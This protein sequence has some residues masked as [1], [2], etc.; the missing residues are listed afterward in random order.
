MTHSLPCAFA[1]GRFTAIAAA[2]LCTGLVGQTAQAATTNLYVSPTGLDTYDCSSLANACSLRHA[3]DRVR[4]LNANM[5]GDII[6]NLAAGSYPLTSTFQLNQLDSG[7]NG[8][9]VIYQGPTNVA[10]PAVL[11]GGKAITGWTVHDSGKNIWKATLPSGVDF[12]Q[13][14]VNGN[15]A[16][17]ARWPNVTNVETGE[18]Y[19]RAVSTVSNVNGTDTLKFVVR[20]ADFKVPSNLVGT[21]VVW[22]NHW[23]HLRARIASFT[24]NSP[25]TQQTTLNFQSPEKANPVFVHF[26]QSNSP[27]YYENALSMLDAPGEWFLDTMRS[28]RV[29]YYIPRA[30]ESMSQAQVAA[31]QVQTLLELA[32]T[33]TSNIHHVQIRNLSFKHSNWHTPSQ[34]GYGVYQSAT[35]LE[36]NGALV[37]AAVSVKNADTVA[38]ENNVLTATGAHGLLLS[39]NVSNYRVVHNQLSDLSAGGIYDEADLSTN[40]LM[41]GNLI[42]KVGRAYTDA[43]GVLAMVPKQ[44]TISYNEIRQTPYTGISLGWRWNNVDYGYDNNQVLNNRIHSVMQVQDDG[45]GIYTLGRM[46]NTVFQGNYVYDIAVAS[47]F[48]GFPSVGIYL[49]QGSTGRT[50]TGN[51]VSNAY[52]YFKINNNSQDTA[53]NSFTGNYYNGA[54]F[55]VTAFGTNTVSGNV[56]VAP[57]SAWPTEAVNIMNNAGI[58]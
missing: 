46:N 49:D 51:V 56:Y 6:V 36:G 24:V 27:F 41:S 43:A 3:R 16:I 53:N 8:Y 25:A 38:L 19:L 9:A 28:P 54:D 40:G 26:P 30:G 39:G 14:Y 12:R 1:R 31:P 50:V 11:S 52:Q 13:L 42:E 55:G 44:L 48:G 7:S 33:S 35:I 34:T 4:T 5:S 20:S 58:R 29:L 32:G 45:G 37:P 47:M 10:T 23:K 22:L 15:R 2:M 18:P 21:E 57:G 17:R